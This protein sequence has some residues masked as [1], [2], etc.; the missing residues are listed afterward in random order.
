MVI[1]CYNQAPYVERA[2]AS[3]VAQTYSNIE[4]IIVDNGSTDDSPEIIK[5]YEGRANTRV[6]LYSENLPQTLV[7]NQAIRMA[8]GEFISILFA[9][10][11]Y[12][13]RK[14]EAQVALFA[15]L[16]ERFGVVY[17]GGYFLIEDTG[18][19]VLDLRPKARGFIFDRLL[20]GP[21]FILPVSPLIRRSCHLEFP[22]YENLKYEGE[23]VLTKIA[24]RYAFD[25]VN[26]PLVV[27]TESRKSQGKKLKET[28]TVNL[29][30]YDQLFDSKEFPKEWVHLKRR[31]KAG[32]LLLKGWQMTREIRAYREGAELALRAVLL[33][34]RRFFDYRGALGCVMGG[35]PVTVADRVSDMLD[36]R[37]KRKQ[38]AVSG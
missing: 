19:L 1:G 34:W 13:P 10:D 14:I 22:F 38:H 16:S 7:A 25:Y 3:V 18:D 23:F 8:T 31:A 2:V 21:A 6:V 24:T 37:S 29:A 20:L 4:L 30:L 32:L 17:S 11:Y 27:V 15:S 12:L 26:E 28:L 9:D 35:V 36:R 5:K 33:D